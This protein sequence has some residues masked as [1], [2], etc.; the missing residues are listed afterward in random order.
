MMCYGRKEHKPS[1]KRY[2]IVFALFFIEH[3]I[4]SVNMYI[5]GWLISTLEEEH[6]VIVRFF[7]IEICWTSVCKDPLDV[8]SI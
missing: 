8:V 5:N 3:F 7:E 1:K 4:D 6:L 2:D